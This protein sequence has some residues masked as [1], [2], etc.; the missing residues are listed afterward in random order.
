MR[1]AEP[2]LWEMVDETMDFAAFAKMIV[3]K[4]TAM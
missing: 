1:E 3:D 2:N 4:N